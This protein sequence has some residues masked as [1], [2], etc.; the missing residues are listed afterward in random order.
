MMNRKH[1]IALGLAGTLA[2]GAAGPSLA[3]SVPANTAA[4]KA[5]APDATTEVRWRGGWGWGPGIGIGLGLGFAG[6][7]LASPYY[8]GGYGCPY[9]GYGYSCGG[10]YA[11]GYGPAYGY[12]AAYAYAP[13]PYYYG[14]WRHRH[15]RWHHW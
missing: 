15:H 12:G 9:Y 3:A 14:G 5:A 6:A 4:V 2:L 7:A 1:A 10:P 8:Y 13:G 11:Y